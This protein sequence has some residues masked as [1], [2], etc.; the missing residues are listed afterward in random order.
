MPQSLVARAISAFVFALSMTACTSWVSVH[1]V[2][3][4]A[5]AEQVRAVMADGQKVVLD[6][7][8]SDQVEELLKRA[9]SVEALAADAR[10]GWSPGFAAAAVVMTAVGAFV[11][12]LVTA[13]LR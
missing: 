6:R 11:L 4:A 1:T 12:P 10:S 8:T 3:D 2:A 5:A 9:K 7:P 13:L